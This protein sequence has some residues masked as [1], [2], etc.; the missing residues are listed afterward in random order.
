MITAFGM[1][2]YVFRAMYPVDVCSCAPTL[3]LRAATSD[4][5]ERRCALVRL[6][7]QVAHS[8]CISVAALRFASSL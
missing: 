8:T 7:S 1:P 2:L 4:S 5:A 6:L 3:P